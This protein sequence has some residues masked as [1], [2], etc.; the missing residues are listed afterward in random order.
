MLLIQPDPNLGDGRHANNAW[1]QE[2][3]RPSSKVVWGNPLLV[4]PAT[5]RRLGLQNGDDV[6]L[7][8]GEARVQAPVWIVPG[9]A[10]DC[11]VAWLGGGRTRAGEVGNGIGVDVTGL[12]GIDG[13]PVLRKTGMRIRVAS[14]DHH[15][16]LDVGRDTVDAIVRHGTLAD[17]TAKP[18]FL[19]D[20]GDGPS[21]YHQPRAEGVAWGM[22]VNLG[23]CIG[24][25]AC[26]VACQAEN[27][28]PVVGKEQV[29]IGR[30][31]ALVTH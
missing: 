30:G 1:L 9:Q 26:V 13:A 10:D 27:N 21:I 28:V 19:S 2:L 7:E 12:R 25:N 15:N 29:L 14:T 23:A 5:A 16:M 31:D 17:F 24:C 3:P 22:S 8:M 11:V 20:P 18:D 6:V 4:A